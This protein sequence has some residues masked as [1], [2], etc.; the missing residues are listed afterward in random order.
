MPVIK[1][2][3]KKL[4]QDKKRTLNNKK[5]RDLLKTALKAAGK[6]STSENISK[7]FKA[8]DKAAKARIIHKNK[9]GRMKSALAKVSL[10][11]LQKL[12]RQ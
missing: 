2:A 9:A 3:K 11:K 1:S 5:L 8:I 7:A 4:R 6:K 10:E 12:R